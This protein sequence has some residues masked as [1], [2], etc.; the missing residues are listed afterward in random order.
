MPPEPLQAAV[1]RFEPPPGTWQAA[2][3]Q[4][5]PRSDPYFPVVGPTAAL[6][7]WAGGPGF[8]APPEAAPQGAPLRSGWQLAQGVWQES[9]IVWEPSA[10]PEPVSGWGGYQQD[11]VPGQS[12]QANG[13]SQMALPPST[14]AGAESAF[15]SMPLGAPTLADAPAPARSQ[16]VPPPARPL[17]LPRPAQAPEAPRAPEPGELFEAW[18][19]SVRKA[20]GRQ[21]KTHRGHGWQV[22]RAGLPIAVIVTVGA[23]A[24]IMLTGKPDNTIADR[25][26]DRIPARGASDGAAISAASGSLTASG[27]S[28]YPGQRGTVLVSSIAAAGGTQLAVGGADGHPAIWRRAGSGAWKLVSGTSPAVFR[29]PGVA[30]LTSIAHGTAGWIAVGDVVSGAVQQSVVVTS[31]DGVTWRALDTMAAFAGPDNFVTGV[32]A[33][34]GGY[35]VVGKQVSKGRVFSAMW[36]SAD[37][38]NWVLG[39]NGGLDGRL[40]S[41]VAYAVAAVPIGF[42][43]AGTHGDCHSVW[44]SPDGRHWTVHDVLV[45]TGAT[46]AMLNLLAVNGNSV[47]A[48]GYAVTKAG[49]IPIVVVSV[50]GGTHWR[51]IVLDAPGGLGAVTALTAAGA[52]FVAAG[53]AG[54]AA[55]GHAVTWR[56]ED[57]NLSWST[58]TQAGSGA[59]RITA[60]ADIGGA[61]TG[62]V[63]QGTDPA[64]VTVPGPQAQR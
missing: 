18:Q 41:S 45:P 51:Q 14:Q 12:W 38:R 26:G 17:P 11:A 9:G 1:A 32:T 40:K 24:V 3:R 27:F 42:V 31:T 53:Q 8:E 52:G 16:T 5:A 43:A 56:T 49:N 13:R 23:G 20:S 47:A 46:S 35:V 4:S 59:E 48:A 22:V 36:W 64:V 21:K 62:T 63:Q 2:P 54:P 7:G 55:A 19:G 44:T 6:R 60:L 15:P 30:K 25:A 34:P 28:G 33:G 50:D 10:E 57:N 61:V 37:L 29:R 39:S 58:A